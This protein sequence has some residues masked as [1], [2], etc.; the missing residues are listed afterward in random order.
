M[1]Q[2]GKYIKIL[3]WFHFLGAAMVVFLYALYAAVHSELGREISAGESPGF[4]W[5]RG[6]INYCLGFGLVYL[7]GVCRLQMRHLQHLSARP[8]ARLLKTLVG[9]ELLFIAASAL[10]MFY[11]RNDFLPLIQTGLLLTIIVQ[12]VY[13]F[14]SSKSRVVDCKPE[15]IQGPESNAGRFLVLLFL[16]GAILALLDPSLQRMADYILLDSQIE[17]RLMRIFPPVL[18]GITCFWFGTGMLVFLFFFCRFTPLI[19][20]QQQS[21]H[22]IP[23]LL[24]IL[25]VAF[26]MAI[27]FGSL[28]NAVN[29]EISKFNLKLFV[30]QLFLL[31]SSGGGVLLTAVFCRISTCLPKAHKAGLVGIVALVFGAAIILPL[32]WLMTRKRFGNVSWRIFLL[33]V[34]GASGFIVYLV[35]FGNIFNPWFT[36]YSFLKNTILKLMAVVAAGTVVLLVSRSSLGD[37]KR[38]RNLGQWATLTV[39]ALLLGFLPFFAIGNFPEVKAVT[40]QFNELTRVDAALA[41]KLGNMLGLGRWIQLGQQ[42]AENGNRHPWPQPWQLKK[43][44]PSALPDDFNL[45]IIVVDALRGDAFHSAGYPRNLTPFLDSWAL[46]EAISFRRAYS[47]GGG[48]FAAFPFF[49]AGRS[50]FTLYGPGLYAENL[51]LKLSRADGIGHFMVMKD[52]GPR[53]IFPPD[54]P[55]IELGIP[56]AVSDRRSATADE[57]FD[58]ARRAI[59]KLPENDRFLC[60][61]HLMDVHN[62]LWKKEGGI[63]FGD[64]PRDLYDNNLSY[65]D[66]A[67]KQ[68]VHWLQQRGLYDRTVIIFTSDHGE[69]FWE[70]GASLHGHTLYEEEIRIPLILYIPGISRRYEK[71][72]VIAADMAPTIVDLA[73][74]TVDPPY[75][76][77]YM[78][79]SL[80]PLIFESVKK[81][82]IKRDIVGRASFKRRYFLF[83]NWEWKLVYFAELD[84]LQLFNVVTDPRE[85]NN[86]VNEEPQLAAQLQKKLFNYLDKVQ[87]KTY[88]T[89]SARPDYR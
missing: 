68:F 8:A 4:A 79:I 17:Y 46:T 75:N 36:A 77:P 32:T 40:L 44:H 5:I 45:L 54:A 13:V 16:F 52:F 57:V 63:D 7:I 65:L 58:S 21:F 82:F 14:S 39:M 29:W 59:A 31:L 6:N 18:S 64:S 2:T 30:L 60:F 35:L 27:L 9:L 43:T 61:L 25:L 24:F 81:Q 23:P 84:L 69:Q 34:L 26:I 89:L 85:K 88:R 87:G 37:L 15:I 50:R 74:Y 28:L 3:P 41:G 33:C 42:P 78:G 1:T 48:S 22:I 19:N 67:F 71:V 10:F 51:Y 86:L 66:G 49:V 83:H 55:V 12:G 70:H 11:H 80:R 62:D 47:Q 72:P 73:G 20:K 76:D 53:G 38:S 56:R